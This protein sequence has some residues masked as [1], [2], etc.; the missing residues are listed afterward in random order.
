MNSLSG[1]N[2]QEIRR[3]HPYLSALLRRV[4]ALEAGAGKGEA[5]IEWGT[6]D[7]I[8][9]TGNR[10]SGGVLNKAARA[11]HQHLFKFPVAVPLSTPDGAAYF[12]LSTSAINIYIGNSPTTRVVAG[13]MAEDV[14]PTGVADTGT[15]PRYAF[16]D[17][18]HPTALLP[19]ADPQTPVVDEI[20]YNAEDKVVRWDGSAWVPLSV[21]TP[22]DVEWGTNADVQPTGLREAGASTRFARA[23]HSHPTAIL[24]RSDPQ[25]PVVDE[26]RYDE[27]NKIVRWNGTNWVRLSFELYVGGMLSDVRPTGLRSA[28]SSSRFAKADHSHPTAILPE[29]NTQY[30]AVDEIRYTETNRLV[31]WNGS[32][33][34][35]FVG[36]LPVPANPLILPYQSQVSSPQNRQLVNHNA[37]D[38]IGNATL[39]YYDSNN[40]QYRLAFARPLVVATSS[41][42]SGKDVW[43]SKANELV[44]KYHP[45][46]TSGAIG[47]LWSRGG[48]SST[49]YPVAPQ[50]T[51]DTTTLLPTDVGVLSRSP[52]TGTSGSRRW[53]LRGMQEGGSI[54]APFVG[55][56]SFTVSSAPA[57]T[58]LSTNLEDGYAYF[59]HDY[60]R[61]DVVRPITDGNKY[62]TM[63][64]HYIIAP[65]CRTFITTT[66]PS[67]HY[68]RDLFWSSIWVIAF[69]TTNSATTNLIATLPTI[70]VPFGIRAGR[71][72]L[73]LHNPQSSTITTNFALLVLKPTSTTPEIAYSDNVSVNIPA[74]TTTVVDV[75]F[76]D[77]SPSSS[78][79][80][81]RSHPITLIVVRRRAYETAN[82]NTVY[83]LSAIIVPQRAA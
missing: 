29:S 69:H 23:D 48:D 18:S 67:G 40:A 30:P 56:P 63:L 57:P 54:R 7:D 3:L 39:F 34:V 35:D 19:Q 51:D 44:L 12:D 33:W 14:K 38:N 13:A 42:P 16:A 60:D 77:F 1:F 17:H 73:Y 64:P 82:S 68:V 76:I 65:P 78:L 74:N 43:A 66:D 22:M 9:P 37:W 79:S 24:P 21:E 47:V 58:D 31:R 52:L 4:K 11:D 25:T 27:D 72:L 26:I 41:T 50:L 6:D 71:G 36:A 49:W 10:N 15:A 83:C 70:A 46:H 8:Q 5:K 53:M 55:F 45:S 61:V 59:I 81:H 32:A 62:C 75:G 2:S 20:R 28:G 80:H